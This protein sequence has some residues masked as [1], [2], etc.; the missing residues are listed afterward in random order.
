MDFN[1]QTCATN[2]GS[3]G[4]GRENVQRK[5]KEKG[6]PW[7]KEECQERAKVKEKDPQVVAGDVE[8][9]TTRSNVPGIRG[10]QKEKDTEERKEEAKEGKVYKVDMAKGL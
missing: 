6:R 5:A 7:E 2:V 1:N 3:Q 9:I 8:E 4:I 10:S